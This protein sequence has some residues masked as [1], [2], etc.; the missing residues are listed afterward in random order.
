MCTVVALVSV[1]LPPARPSSIRRK[2]PRGRVSSFWDITNRFSWY[3]R[4]SECG[5]PSARAKSFC[6]SLPFNVFQG[7]VIFWYG[8]LRK[9]IHTSLLALCLSGD[10]LCLGLTVVVSL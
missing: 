2:A 8:L 9:E 3:T 10:G 4:R 5:T 1:L 6:N 7:I